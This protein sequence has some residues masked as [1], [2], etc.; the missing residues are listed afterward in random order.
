MFNYLF[1]CYFYS[2]IVYKT[3]TDTFIMKLLMKISQYSL[4]LK[5]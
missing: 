1:I 5:G 2:L 4:K 3:V